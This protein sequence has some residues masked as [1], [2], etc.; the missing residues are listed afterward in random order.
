MAANGTLVYVPAGADVR[1]IVAVNR[2]GQSVPVPGLPIGRFT[3]VRVSPDGSRVA[4]TLRGDIWI[5]TWRA[6][7]LLN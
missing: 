5:M 7:A 2:K 6:E 1:Q 3:D 4:L